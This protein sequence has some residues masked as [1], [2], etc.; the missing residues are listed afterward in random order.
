MLTETV[1]V[2]IIA[3]FGVIAAAALTYFGV[4]RSSDMSRMSHLESR[5]DDSEMVNK[6][7]WL[8]NRGLQDQVFRGDP[9]PPREPPD[10][11]KARLDK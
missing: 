4:K 9:P 6:G 11:L 8:W 7:L 3:C 2:A 10:W 5:L 1:I